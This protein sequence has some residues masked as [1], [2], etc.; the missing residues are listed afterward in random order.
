[1][2]RQHTRIRL[3]NDP[4]WIAGLK[5]RDSHLGTQQSS[6][7]FKK[8]VTDWCKI[9]FLRTYRRCPYIGGTPVQLVAVWAN[10]AVAL[11]FVSETLPAH[12]PDICDIACPI[13]W[14]A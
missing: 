3:H 11:Q 12:R 5:G 7:A 13:S 1:M 6:R 10:H 9:E 8:H 4:Q 2:P 14:P